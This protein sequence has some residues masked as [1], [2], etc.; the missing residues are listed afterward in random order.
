MYEYGSVWYYCKQAR[1]PNTDLKG[2]GTI[3]ANTINQRCLGNMESVLNA[4]YS[5]KKITTNV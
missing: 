1:K 2:I 4:Y 5:R 3:T